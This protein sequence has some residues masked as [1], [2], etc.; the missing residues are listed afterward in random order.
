M[1]IHRGRISSGDDAVAA[2]AMPDYAVAIV[3]GGPAGLLAARELARTVVPD[4]ICLI[5]R[6]GLPGSRVCRAFGVDCTGCRECEF[7]EGIGG[8]GFYVDGKLCEDADVGQRYSVPSDLFAETVG[9]LDDIRAASSVGATSLPPDPDGAAASRARARGFDVTTYPVKFMGSDR[10][11]QLSRVLV[12]ELVGAGVRVMHRTDV[13]DLRPEG[14]GFVLVCRTERGLD[15][16]GAQ[17]VLL[18]VGRAGASWLEDLADRVGIRTTP[19]DIDVGVRLETPSSILAPLSAIG[20]NPKLRLRT[21]TTS[22]KTHCLCP[23]GFVISYGVV[24]ADLLVRMVDGHSFSARPSP[25]SNV[26]LLMRMDAASVTD[27]VTYAHA[28]AWMSNLVGHGA[29]ILQRVGDLRLSRPSDLA[30]IP[31][32]GFTPT[33]RTASGADLNLAYPR[34]LIEGI[35]VFLDA[36]DAVCPGVASDDMVVYGPAMEW[37]VGRAELSPEYETSLPGLYLA[38]DATGKTSGVLTAAVTG[39]HAARCMAASL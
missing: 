8:A 29:P 25:N 24:A 3:G 27:P 10:V 28:L 36:L 9:L 21:G 22:V 14:T 20:G 18:A 13:I 17:R 7:I 1:R 31:N 5:D 30:S 38:G 39:L 4:S 37:Y 26:N 16:L 23:D 35:L 34:F 6:G 32:G 11:R 19:N 15:Q 12:D 2:H 33:L